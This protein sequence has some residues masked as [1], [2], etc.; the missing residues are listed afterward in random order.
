MKEYGGSQY[1][2]PRFLNLGTSWRWVVSFTHRSLYLL[3]KSS[4]YP[5]DGRLGGPQNR[6]GWH[7]QNSYHY[8]DSNSDPS[9]VQP[10]ASHYTDW[11][12]PTLTRFFQLYPQALAFWLCTATRTLSSGLHSNHHMESSFFVY[13]I[14]RP[15][16][17][18]W[19]RK[20]IT[21]HCTL[22]VHS[23][24]G[25][26]IVYSKAMRIGCEQIKEGTCTI[27]ASEVYFQT[28]LQKVG[29]S[30]FRILKN[31]YEED[32]MKSCKR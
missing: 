14:T 1:I 23:I 3:R 6:S 7:A 27:L 2:H 4:R 9:I 31:K 25:T 12:I 16:R 29:S 24:Q 13:F 26:V 10:V 8:R 20:L 11:A 19:S 18:F 21:D 22:S 30:Y 5:L 28:L 15:T 17:T 32:G